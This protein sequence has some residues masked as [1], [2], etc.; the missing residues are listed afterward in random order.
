MDRISP[1]LVSDKSGVDEIDCFKVLD[2]LS[3]FGLLNEKL[4][5]A[6]PHCH[7]VIGKYDTINDL[8]N[9]ARCRKCGMEIL[10][11]LKDTYVV[12]EKS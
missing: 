9:T 12:F 5:L 8:P 3:G 7:L 4:L 10:S 11:A 1:K 6:C 2:T